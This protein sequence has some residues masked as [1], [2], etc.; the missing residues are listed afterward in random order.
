[1]LILQAHLPPER[2]PLLITGISGV[3]GY[4]ALAYF[5]HR[6]P[7]R[8]IGVRPTQTW[9]LVGPGVEALDTEDCDGMRAL[10][11]RHGFRSVLNTTGNCALKSCELDPAMAQRT[12][13]TSAA[14]LVESAR[15]FHCRLVHLSSDLVYSGVGHGNYVEI[16]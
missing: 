4:N 13:V 6:Y 7:G 5:Q 14:N 10:F 1:M 2:L 12:N 15:D 3:A 16:D 11:R 9:Q 8:V